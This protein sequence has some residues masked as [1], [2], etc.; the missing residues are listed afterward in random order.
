MSRK[1]IN[2]LRGKYIYIV[3]IL[4]ILVGTVISNNF[5][6]LKNFLNVIDNIS[7]LGIVAGGMA[8]VTYSGNFSDLSVPSVMALSGLITVKLLKY[9]IAISIICAMLIA[10]FIGVINGVVIG[11]LKAH[12]IVWTLAFSFVITGFTRFIFGSTHIYPEVGALASNAFANLYRT[13]LFGVVP[14]TVFIMFVILIIM[15]FIVSKTLFGEQ[16]KFVAVSPPCANLSGINVSKIIGFSFIISSL[17]ASV[18][19]IFIASLSKTGAYYYGAGYDFSALTAIILGGVTLEGGKGN[20]V[21]V[22]GGVLSLGFLDNILTLF[23]ISTFSQGVIKGIVF[24]IIVFITNYS[25]RKEGGRTY[26]RWI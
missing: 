23:G 2:K 19:G 13:K 22:F 15:H 25:T 16:L 6:T 17:T 24:I 20:I 5:L 10:F 18:A 1:I 12:P 4:E 3:L 9:N 14:A 7:L 8:L 21:G 26:A 11:K